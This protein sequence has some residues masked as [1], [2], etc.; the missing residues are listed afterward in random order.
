VQRINDA[1][2]RLIFLLNRAARLDI[3]QEQVEK[4]LA[5]TTEA[6]RLAQLMERPSETAQA[7]I[8]FINLS[9]L[10][11]KIDPKPHVEAI[12]KMQAGI[13]TGWARER[14]I[15]TLENYG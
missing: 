11:N 14:A 15:A 8:N 13:L 6:L 12:E 3:E 9:K 1:K 2:L 10:N 5:R 4:A 7:H